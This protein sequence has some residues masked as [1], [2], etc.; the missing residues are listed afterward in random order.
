VLTVEEYDVDPN[1][2]E[3]DAAT[4]GDE[5]EQKTREQLRRQKSGDVTKVVIPATRSRKAT[6]LD[7][8]LV[9]P[10]VA[11]V[12]NVLSPWTV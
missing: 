8:D 3:D 5:H 10:I 11:H 6:R 1:S 9:D 4:L 2:V 7:T 12:R